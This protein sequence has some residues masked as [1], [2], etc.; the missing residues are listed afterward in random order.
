MNKK[1]SKTERIALITKTLIEN[2]SQIFTL[3]YFSDMLDHAKSTL[4][5]DIKSIEASFEKYH[6][7]KIYSI[8]GAAG[9]VYY[10]PLAHKT[11]VEKVQTDLCNKLS[12]TSR[13]IPGGYLYM[14][15]ILYDPSWLEKIALCIVS[16]YE[17]ASMDYV[18]TIETKG[19]PLALAVARILNKPI[20]VIRKSARLT[21]GTTLQM[22]YVTGSKQNIKTMSMPIKSIKR[23]SKVLF[24]DDFMKAGGT[25][26]GVVDFMK[27]FEAQVVGVAVMMSTITTEE[28]LVQS[29]YSLIDFKGIDEKN[30]IIHMIPSN[31][32]SDFT[33]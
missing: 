6:L 12:E 15:D 19:I 17:S 13:I 9:G 2:P 29:Y 33:L 32:K 1:I 21:E 23:G 8:S 18:V 7:G 24:V 16:Y 20:V 3:N 11:F 25:A 5:E 22:N 10:L 4:S 31:N 27:E 30:K 28:K 26:K 14:N